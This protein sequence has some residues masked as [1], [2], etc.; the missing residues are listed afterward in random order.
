VRR[1]L[2]LACLLLGAWTVI[3]GSAEG[4]DP[5]V[6]HLVVL[7]DP[8]LPGEFLSAKERVRETVNG[9]PDATAVVALGDLCQ[10][11]GT[12]EEYAAVKRYFAGF[13]VPVHPLV[14]N[15][16]Y[17]YEDAKD[18]RGRRRL[19]SPA[20]RGAKLER[21]QATFGLPELFRSQRVG[22]Y[23]LV[24]LA[25][26]HPLSRN[27]AEMSSR[28]VAWLRDLLAAESAPTLLFFH[29]PLQGTLADFNEHANT[30]SFVA[31]PRQEIH[32]LLLAH[33]SVFL[34][35]SGHMHVSAKNASYAAPI[36]LYAGR[37]LAI[38]T[39]DMN[40]ASIWTN[41][42]FLYSDRVVIRTFDHAQ[43]AWMPRL[44]RT[45]AAP[46]R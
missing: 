1:L 19:G 21:F 28:Q 12:A 26:D 25:A 31:Q 36:N 8:H 17:I 44:E 18:A 27:L 43:G 11:L 23:R 42:L 5:D 24:F 39:P 14:G 32:D 29:A 37:V 9:W 2:A 20:S 22:P 33:P 45:V 16:D 13:R 40:R 38:H 4:A 41:S 10:D 15:H 7:G 34:W 35:V 46:R 6:R 3:G 30:Q